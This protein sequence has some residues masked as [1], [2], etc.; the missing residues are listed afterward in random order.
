MQPKVTELIL[1]SGIR[2]HVTPIS[3]YLRNAL[4]EEAEALF[5]Y[6]DKKQYEV[7]LSEDVAIPGTVVPADEHPEY[8]VFVKGVDNQRQE[9][10]RHAMLNLCVKYPDFPTRRALIEH[11]APY[12]DEQREWLTLPE[13]DWQAT[14]RFAVIG[15]PSDEGQ[16]L[17]VVKDELPVTEAETAE[18]LRVFQ[19]VLSKSQSR[20]LDYAR[21]H[22]SGAEAK[23]PGE[24]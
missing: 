10:I 7:E 18:N 15:S 22:A 8:R 11:F 12:L 14:L 21:K 6:P 23:I 2:V 9:Y 3:R 1:D 20:I 5:P 19:P 13:D 24:E 16:I 17:A 4:V